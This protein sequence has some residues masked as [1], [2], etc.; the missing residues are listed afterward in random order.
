MSEDEDAMQAEATA[1]ETPMEAAKSL[2][3]ETVPIVR[4]EMHANCLKRKCNSFL[5]RLI[6]KNR[7]QNLDLSGYFFNHLS[8]FYIFTVSTLF[9]RKT[10][11]LYLTGLFLFSD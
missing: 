2:T 1:I 5:V 3:V 8:Q 9:Q 10:F 6:V 7:C 4:H 11:R